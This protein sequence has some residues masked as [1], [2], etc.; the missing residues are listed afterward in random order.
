VV[1]V[2]SSRICPSFCSLDVLTPVSDSLTN[3]R[4]SLVVLPDQ[5]DQSAGSTASVASAGLFG[6]DGAASVLWA[7][8]AGVDCSVAGIAAGSML[9]GPCF[10]PLLGLE[11]L[12]LQ[13]PSSR[14]VEVKRELRY[15]RTVHGFGYAFQEMPTR[16]MRCA[17]AGVLL[18]RG[19]QRA[20]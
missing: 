2:V 12:C 19:L 6:C 5:L 17:E 18:F 11:S 7:T 3:A 13:H 9:I 8:P 14:A 10:L 4:G 15:V 20:R 16:T 1:V